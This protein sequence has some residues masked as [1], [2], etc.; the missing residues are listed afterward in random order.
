MSDEIRKTFV[1]RIDEEIVYETEVS[2]GNNI[3]EI[4]SDDSSCHIHKK[5]WAAIRDF[6]NLELEKL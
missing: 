1:T 5:E 4:E 2:I 6:I 3:V